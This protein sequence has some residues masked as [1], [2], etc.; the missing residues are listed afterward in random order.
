[1]SKRIERTITTPSVYWRQEVNDDELFNGLLHVTTNSDVP[2]I[3][4]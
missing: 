4:G 2:A 3:E 1:M